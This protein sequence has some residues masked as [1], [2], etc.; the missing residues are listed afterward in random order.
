M[1]PSLVHGWQRRGASAIA[2][3]NHAM[4]VRRLFSLK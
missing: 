2:K 4:A 3:L 1:Y